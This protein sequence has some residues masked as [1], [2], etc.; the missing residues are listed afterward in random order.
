MSIEKDLSAIAEFQGESLTKNLS[1]IESQISGISTSECVELCNSFGVDDELIGSVRAVKKVAGQINVIL[2]AT[3]IMNSLGRLLKDGEEVQSVSLGAGNTGR[4][5]D[6]ETNFQV[7]EFKFIDWQG[8]AE[9]IRQ[10]ALFKDF[11]NLAEFES[12]KEKNLYVVGIEHPLKFFN[13]GRALT[14]V[15]SK[16][17]AILESIKI[18]YGNSVC[19]TRDYYNLHKNSV[20]VRDVSQYLTHI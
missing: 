9:T 1:I 4:R 18:K 5:F 17:P 19:K 14:S 20:Q 2:H 8:G 12:K 11:H 6:L 10:N 15:L 3:G 7:A 13:G 16:Q